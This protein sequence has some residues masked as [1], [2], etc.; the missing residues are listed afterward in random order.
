MRQESWQERVSYKYFIEDDPIIFNNMR[1]LTGMN[2]EC[3]EKRATLTMMEIRNPHI[4]VERY[5]DFTVLP[6]IILAWRGDIEEDETRE[7]FF[8]IFNLENNDF[9]Q[10]INNA[11]FFCF[12]IVVHVSN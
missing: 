1:C 4:T 2:S 10:R 11:I 6:T 8:I 5:V 3:L 12:S 9:S 7:M